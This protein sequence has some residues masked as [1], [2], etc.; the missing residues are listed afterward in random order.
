MF[1]ASLEVIYEHQQAIFKGSLTLS[2]LPKAWFL[3]Q[4]R[5]RSIDATALQKL[6]TAGALFILELLKGRPDQELL[7]GLNP[8]QEVLLNLVS[9]QQVVNQFTKQK[10]RLAVKPKNSI[11]ARILKKLT[12][13]GKEVTAKALEVRD[14]LSLIGELFCEFL[15]A[16]KH[17][18]RFPYKNILMVIQNMG[19]GALPILGLLALL[20]GVVLAYQLGV[21]LQNYGANIYIAYLTGIA[22]LREFGPLITA[23]IIAGRSS[24]AFTA[25]IGAMKINQEIDALLTLGISPMQR[26]VLPKVLG[27]LLIF[28]FLIFWSDF[29]GMLGSMLMARASLS[30][31]FVPFI[32]E[33][34]SSVDLQHLWVGLVKAP[35]F[36]LIIA[37]VGCHQG[38]KVGYSAESI[39][40]CTTQSVVQAIFLIIIADALF[41]ILFNYLG[42]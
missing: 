1:D 34:R 37:L 12:L 4:K 23:V 20:I 36:A 30:I 14:F 11:S 7:K 39:G 27:M 2:T 25:E 18:H 9:E 31:N 21:Q 40:K 38:F 3:K 22:I 15:Q 16:L 24:S 41:S 42:V 29:M 8:D 10:P 19:C 28:P 5:V 26:L 32:Y 35:I 33:F 6:D 17:I 13:L